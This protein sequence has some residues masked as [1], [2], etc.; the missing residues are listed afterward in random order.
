M[1]RIREEGKGVSGGGSYGDEGEEKSQYMETC[2]WGGVE[3]A[4]EFFETVSFRNNG[5]R[6]QFDRLS[7]KQSRNTVVNKQDSR[8]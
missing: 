8:P 7:T 2:G 1:V 6:G 4:R 3:M 5:W